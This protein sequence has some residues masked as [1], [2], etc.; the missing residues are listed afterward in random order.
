MNNEKGFAKI[1]IGLLF[2][3]TG[4]MSLVLGYLTKVI[5]SN[6]SKFQE[7]I[8][9][10]RTTLVSKLLPESAITD[11]KNR[12][13][14]KKALDLFHWGLPLS[15][16]VFALTSILF[17]ITQE[18]VMQQIAGFGFFGIIYGF[19]GLIGNKVIK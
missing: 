18:P 3:L 1:I 2:V 12:G 5:L 19:I 8:K 7:F 16:I 15:I 17:N 4:I 6:N 11:L 10:N 13:I 9:K 14:L